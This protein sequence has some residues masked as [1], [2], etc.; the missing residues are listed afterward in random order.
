MT[1]NIICSRSSISEAQ[2]EVPLT[3]ACLATGR[4]ISIRGVR[5]SI[6][7]Q[8]IQILARKEAKTLLLEVLFQNLPSLKIYKYSH[9][10]TF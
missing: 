3:W 9:T 2:S 8:L 7:T 6:R 5:T 4:A 1:P 10:S